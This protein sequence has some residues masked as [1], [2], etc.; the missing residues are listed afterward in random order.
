MSPLERR[1]RML[2]FGYPVG[3]RETRGEE[4]IGTLLEATPEDRTWPLPRDV[5]AIAIGALRARFRL[6]RQRTTV[7]NLR[8]AVVVGVA[9]YL[10]QDAAVWFHTVAQ[11]CTDPYCRSQY[12]GPAWLGP[13]LVAVGVVLACVSR[14]RA[15]ILCAVLPAAVLVWLAPSGFVY[16]FGDPAVALA[17]LAVLVVLAGGPQRPG[18]SWLWPLGMIAVVPW[19]QFSGRPVL[20]AVIGASILWIIIVD[21]KLAIA[22]VILLLA[23][24]LS[25]ILAFPRASLLS[26]TTP[27]FL[28]ILAV[29]AA[30]GIWLLRRQSA[31]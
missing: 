1:C 31:R 3:Y 13:A 7:A 18:A 12:A 25:S 8:I 28:A 6:N 29:L 26:P 10:C 23:M 22:E 16:L 20:V 30:P 11:S 5:L 21:A 19:L 14:W 9:A 4:I 15:V 2:L 24:R 17:S 27:L